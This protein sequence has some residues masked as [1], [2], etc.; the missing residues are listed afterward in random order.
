MD[1]QH[2]IAASTDMREAR[3]G[4]TRP[5][6]MDLGERNIRAMQGFVRG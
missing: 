2:A 1:R 5:H 3:A 6:G 4:A